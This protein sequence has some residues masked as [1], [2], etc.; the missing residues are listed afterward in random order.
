MVEPSHEMNRRITY[1]VTRST[2][3]EL[4]LQGREYSHRLVSRIS[5]PSSLCILTSQRC[6]KYLEDLI[7]LLR[8][9]TESLLE[10]VHVGASYEAPLRSASRMALPSRG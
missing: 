1:F 8:R 5:I 9:Q 10:F 2:S 6:A 7:N 3:Y 4:T